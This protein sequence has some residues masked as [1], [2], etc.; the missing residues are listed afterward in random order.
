MMSRTEPSRRQQLLDARTNICRQIETLEGG[1]T[2][3]DQG[4]EFIEAEIA[5]SDLKRSLREI[6]DSLVNLGLEDV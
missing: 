1:P 6:E 4:C 3:S 2:A 5:I